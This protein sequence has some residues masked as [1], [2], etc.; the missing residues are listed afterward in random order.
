MAMFEVSVE[1]VFSA[2]HQVILSDGKKE[3]VHGHDWKVTVTFAGNELDETGFLVDFIAAEKAL[4]GIVEQL[5]HT[6]LNECPAMCGMNPSAEH[7]ARIIGDYVAGDKTV[8]HA[9]ARINLT[10]AP[11]CSATYIP[12]KLNR[13]IARSIPSR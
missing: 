1:S 4:S 5:N 2:S 3:P 12:A 10:E 7:V 13:E 9:F 6:S 11:G 8:G